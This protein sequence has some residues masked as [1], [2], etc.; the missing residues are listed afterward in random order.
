MKI[1]TA[2]LV[3]SL[4]GINPVLV[5]GTPIAQ[6][7]FGS[8]ASGTQTAAVVDPNATA[9][10]FTVSSG[11]VNFYQGTPPADLAIG[12][13]GWKVLDGDKWWIFTVTANA[14]YVLDLRRSRLTTSG[15]PPVRR[16]GR[17]L[18]M[19]RL[20]FPASPPPARLPMTLFL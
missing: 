19:A 10:S 6:W 18:S 7:N 13:I 2:I 11:S 4:I 3:C 14:G 15:P 5:M 12:M 1:T 20:F 8:G 9:T 17:C 16:I